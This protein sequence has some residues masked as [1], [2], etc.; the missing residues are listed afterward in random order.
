[1]QK[2]MYWDRNIIRTRWIYECGYI[3]GLSSK[4]SDRMGDDTVIDTE[5]VTQ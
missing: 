4:D 2:W 3:R 5:T 1:M